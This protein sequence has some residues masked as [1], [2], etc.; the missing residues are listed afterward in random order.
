M[1]KTE[2]EGLGLGWEVW[3]LLA[4]LATGGFLAVMSVSLIGGV[5]VAVDQQPI[6]GD[7]VAVDLRRLVAGGA[8]AVALVV[9]AV[10]LLVITDWSVEPRA[11]PGADR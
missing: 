4:V 6:S 11:D 8:A 10:R 3:F 5:A 2:D 1:S 7:A 9:A